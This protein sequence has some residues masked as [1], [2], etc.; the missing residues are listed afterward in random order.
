MNENDADSPFDM[1]GITDAY[2][3]SANEKLEQ[4]Q[5]LL[6]EGQK[7][8]A[9]GD[10]YNLVSVVFS[11]VLFLLGIVGIF[12][13]MPNRAAVLIIAAVGL[14]ITT[15]YMCTLPMPTGFDIKNFI[16]L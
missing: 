9:K 11:L 2:F 13:R 4:S 8:N 5:I 6:E 15:I 16:G 12:K 10:A 1:P 7:D 3:V 14:V